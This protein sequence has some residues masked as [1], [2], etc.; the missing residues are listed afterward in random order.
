MDP[1]KLAR[2]T[3]AEDRVILL[4]IVNR[5]RQLAADARQDQAVRTGNE[6]GDRVRRMLPRGKKK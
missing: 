3:D 2:E 1:L 6:V 5:A 4:A